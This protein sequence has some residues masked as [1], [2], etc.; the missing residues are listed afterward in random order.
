[1]PVPSGE[2]ATEVGKDGWPWNGHA[3]LL[4]RHVI[5]KPDCIIIRARDYVLAVRC[6][7]DIMDIP[8]VSLKFSDLGTCFEVPDTN[9]S[10]VRA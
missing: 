7:G 6:K 3:Y 5:P 10:V 9:C 1:M 2:N 8:C 4:A